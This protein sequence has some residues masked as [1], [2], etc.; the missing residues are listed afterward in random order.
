[1]KAGS[2]VMGSAAP[3]KEEKETSEPE[4]PNVLEGDV[5]PV[6]ARETG[7]LNEVDIVVAA[8]DRVEV[9]P[10]ENAEDMQRTGWAWALDEGL[11]V[12]GECT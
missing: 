6:L 4:L 2:W 9:T 5:E 12:A 7:G 1:M 8:V 11:V 10:K 3:R